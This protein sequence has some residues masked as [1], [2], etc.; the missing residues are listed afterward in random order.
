M[1]MLNSLIIEGYVANDIENTKSE[2]EVSVGKFTIA[3]NRFYKDRNDENENETSFFE[4]E[5]YGVLCD[6]FYKKI[7]KGK[8]IHVVGL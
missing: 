6:S 2:T 8:G 5:C 7:T 4:C 1:D 3:V